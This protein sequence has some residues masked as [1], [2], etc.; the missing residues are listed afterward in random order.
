MANKAEIILSAKDKSAA[1]FKSVTSKAKLL[2]STIGKVGGALGVLGG[3][4]GLVGLVALTKNVLNANDELAKMSQ[5]IGISVEALAGLQHAGSLAGVSLEQIQKGVKS[6]SG[7]LFD[8][9]SGLI[10]SQRNFDA[11]GVSVKD[12]KGDLRGA[13][14]VII[15]L[16]DK[17]ADMKDGTEKTALAVK[18]FG[19][20]GL[21]MIPLLNSGSDAL[22]RMV[23]EGKELNPVT[24]ETARQS[25]IFNDNMER[26]AG[27]LRQAGIEIANRVIPSISRLSE[28][29]AGAAFEGKNFWEV[30]RGGLVNLT[31]M[32]SDSDNT[33]IA[34]R[35]VRDEIRDIDDELRNLGKDSPIT[36]ILSGQVFRLAADRKVL[37]DQEAFLARKDA[38]EKKEIFVNDNLTNP[39]KSF[40][41][42]IENQTEENKKASEL[43]N[44][45]KRQK[46]FVE[47]LEKQ[48]AAFGLNAEQVALLNAKE[49]ELNETDTKRVQV[50]AER[51]QILTE[52][53]A[54]QKAFQDDLEKKLNA[55]N[56][57][58]EAEQEEAKQAEDRRARNELE[59][60][61]LDE[62]KDKREIILAQFDNEIVKREKIIEL[63]KLDLDEV[64]RK[65][66]EA[67]IILNEERANG[68]AQQ[69]AMLEKQKNISDDMTQFGI[70]AARNLQT[71]F[72]DFLFDPFEDG[73][74]GML[75]GFAKVLQ[76]MVAEAA[77]KQVLQA[78]FGASGDIFGGGGLFGSVASGIGGFLGFASGGDHAGGFRIVGEHGAE[79][80]ATGASRIF[81]AEQTKD[82]LNGNTSS[83]KQVGDTIVTKVDFSVGVQDTVRR[84]VLEMMPL[85]EKRVAA[86]VGKSRSRGG[87][88]GKPLA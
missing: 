43:A 37:Q 21:E 22:A 19:K 16:A 32:Q 39:T 29:F 53:Q 9:S 76:R 47:G 11:L 31:D 41:A 65:Q 55:K 28:V 88:E 68:L 14:S 63:G 61:L 77:S 18:L 74:D 71:A 70:Q 36:S 59:L 33:A 44:K 64:T 78:L 2:A 26:L 3:G 60:S 13:E 27:K 58:V 50:A 40:S 38:V 34:L 42:N 5:K 66:L 84:E 75:I 15:E 20:S 1:A 17:F 56:A 67:Q 23:A 24:A 7:Q 49:L 83:T 57:L 69:E 45:L 8:A 30:L 4:A 12:A 86:A 72:A 25:E 80:E 73:L 46:A 10:E 82:I 87:R 35:R 79:L 6:V 85:I 48:A 54:L 52:D 81:N 62:S 51:L